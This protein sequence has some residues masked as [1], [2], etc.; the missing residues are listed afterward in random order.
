VKIFQCEMLTANEKVVRCCDGG[1]YPE[2]NF[3]TLN[4]YPEKKVL[5]KRKGW[6]RPPLIVIDDDGGDI[7]GDKT[8]AALE[9]YLKLISDCGGR[10]SIIP[11]KEEGK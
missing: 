3:C 6:H 7:K 11:V 9:P 1:L 10:V 8:E 4:K 2:C 5:K